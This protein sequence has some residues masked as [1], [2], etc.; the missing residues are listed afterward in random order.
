MKKLQ[1]TVLVTA[2]TM[3]AQ[4]AVTWAP[5]APGGTSGGS[6]SFDPTGATAVNGG[7][8]L[9]TGVAGTAIPNYTIS[10]WINPA[11]VSG[12]SWFFGTGSQGLHL[13]IRDTK[14]DDVVT[15]PGTLSQGHWGNDS[16]GTTSISANSWSHVTYTY[17]NV[18]ST[19]SI[20]LNGEL[21]AAT[22]T[23]DPNRTNTD[24]IIGARD[25][26]RTNRQPFAGLVDDV[27]IWNSVIS[28]ED[29]LAVADGSKGA[30]D[31]G[32]QAYWDFEDDQ[33]GFEA[34]VQGTLGSALAIP[35]P[36]SLA[37]VLVGAAG[38]LRRKRA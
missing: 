10:M 25:G 33:A 7:T 31:A 22:V 11:S 28:E 12:E 17:D 8:F 20:Y 38:L 36:S 29:I 21:D 16:D 1:L 4:G 3:N 34:A 19:Q 24:L 6:A 18:T 2:L 13:G 30:V 27:A 32:A 35:E 23:G 26:G 14:V 15:T 9:G 37:L 5:G